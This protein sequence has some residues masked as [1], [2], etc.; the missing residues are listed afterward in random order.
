M[1]MSWRRLRAAARSDRA[2]DLLDE[3]AVELACLDQRHQVRRRVLD[4]LDERILFLDRLEVGTRPDGRLGGDHA[5]APVACRERR[6]RRARAGRRRAAARRSAGADDGRAT[7]LDVLHA[8]TIALTSR[9]ASSSRHSAEKR[10]TSSSVRGPYGRARVVAEV[11]RRLVRQP[12]HHLA[13]ARSGHRRQ[14]R[15]SRWRGCLSCANDRAFRVRT[16]RRQ[17]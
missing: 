16:P 9:A 15:R 10:R 17:Q 4:D 12:P 7:A 1:S 5:D 6:G 11:D 8:T 3:A 14:S 2:D 13:Q